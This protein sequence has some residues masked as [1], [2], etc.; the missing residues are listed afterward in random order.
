MGVQRQLPDLGI[1]DCNHSP[2]WSSHQPGNLT[3]TWTSMQQCLHCCSE[4][5]RHP[6]VVP[7]HAPSQP[8]SKCAVSCNE[9]V[10]TFS[11]RGLATT[12]NLQLRAEPQPQRPMGTSVSNKS[13]FTTMHKISSLST[14]LHVSPQQTGSNAGCA[15]L[16]LGAAAHARPLH[17]LC[18]HLRDLHRIGP[19]LTKTLISSE[20]SRLHLRAPLK[21]PDMVPHT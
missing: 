14:D 2:A 6:G 17:L 5:P 16:T 12:Q 19:G 13:S 4:P 11:K 1:S 10:L 7:P 20:S 15:A 9:V 8:W 21:P 18:Q 3:R